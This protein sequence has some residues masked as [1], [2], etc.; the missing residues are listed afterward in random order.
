MPSRT[1]A[2]STRLGGLKKD[3]EKPRVWT[4]ASSA[5]ATTPSAVVASR[6]SSTAEL[7]GTVSAIFR[8]PAGLPSLRDSTPRRVEHKKRG[9]HE[10]SC[11]EAPPE[12]ESGDTRSGRDGARKN[13]GE[14]PS[15][16]PNSVTPAHLNETV[17]SPSARL[18][19][20][21]QNP[22][23]YRSDG[24]RLTLSGVRDARQVAGLSAF[25]SQVTTAPRRFSSGHRSALHAAPCQPSNSFQATRGSRTASRDVS[26]G[27]NRY[28]E[29]EDA[30]GSTLHA[31]ASAA[32]PPSSRVAE[33]KSSSCD[34]VAF[35]DAE[36]PSGSDDKRSQS[37]ADTGGVLNK[38]RSASAL[39]SEGVS[40]WEKKGEEGQKEERQ[41]SAALASVYLDD[42]PAE[43]VVA[44]LEELRSFPR[45]QALHI[46]LWGLDWTPEMIRLLGQVFAASAAT[47]ESVTLRCRVSAP[48]LTEM[49]ERLPTNVRYLDVSENMLGGDTTVVP[50]L[51]TLLRRNAIESLKVS[52]VGWSRESKELFAKAV[53]N[54]G[55]F[56]CLQWLEGVDLSEW[57]AIPPQV[58]MQAA[59]PGPPCSS[60]AATTAPLAHLYG[61]RSGVS[62]APGA[63]RAAAVAL[64]K[65]LPATTVNYTLL[66][67][68]RIRTFLPML[69]GKKVRVWWKPTSETQRTDFS[70]R[71]WPAR[72]V[73]G[74]TD[75]LVCKL[76]YDNNEQDFIS[77]RYLQPY[78]PFKY[79]G[80]WGCL[81]D[82]FPSSS[83]VSSASSSSSSSQPCKSFDMPAEPC[84][85]SVAETIRCEA[86]VGR[87]ASRGRRS[88]AAAS[89]DTF[90]L[91][92]S[93]SERLSIVSEASPVVSPRRGRR[94]RR[95]G[96]AARGAGLEVEETGE[97][98]ETRE[99]EEGDTVDAGS[100][101][102]S[103]RESAGISARGRRRR[104]PR[105][106]A[107]LFVSAP[108]QDE[109]TG[110]QTQRRKRRRSAGSEGTEARQSA[111]ENPG[112]ECFLPPSEKGLLQRASSSGR[113]ACR[114]RPPAPTRRS[115]ESKAPFGCGRR[116]SP[117][118]QLLAQGRQKSH[119]S[120]ESSRAQ[121]RE[122]P[123]KG[124]GPVG[125]GDRAASP[126]RL[127][128]TLRGREGTG[129]SKERDDTETGVMREAQKGVKTAR[130]GLGEF[131]REEGL[132]GLGEDRAECVYLESTDTGRGRRRRS[133]EKSSQDGEKEGGRDARHRAGSRESDDRCGRREAAEA[134]GIG[135]ALERSIGVAA[136]A[137]TRMTREG[138]A[139]HV[140][141]TR[142]GGAGEEA[143]VRAETGASR[144]DKD[145]GE[146]REQ[147]GDRPLEQRRQRGDCLSPGTDEMRDQ[148][149]RD[150]A[151]RAQGTGEQRRKSDG[152]PLDVAW[153]VCCGPAP[154]SRQEV[155]A[156][157]S[158][159]PDLFE[160]SLYT[161]LLSPERDG[162][163]EEASERKRAA[164]REVGEERKARGAPGE[165]F[166][167]A[168][169]DSPAGDAN[170]K[171]CSRPGSRALGT[172]R[173][174]QEMRKAKED[175]EK[176]EREKEGEA[177]E[178]GGEKGE[179][180]VVFETLEDATVNCEEGR[181][182]VG[183][184][185]L[186]VI[187]NVLLPGELCEF[188]DEEEHRGSDPSDFVGMVVAV[189]SEEP[190]YVVRCV[191]HDDDTLLQIQ[192]SDIRR[193]VVVPLDAW[194][195]WRFA[196]ERFRLRSEESSSTD[197]AQRGA[198]RAVRNRRE[199]PPPPASAAPLG[200][201]K[202]VGA[203]S[204]EL[205][206]GQACVPERRAEIRSPLNLGSGQ[207]ETNLPAATAFPSFR[208]V[209]PFAAFYMLPIATS[210]RLQQMAAAG[211]PSQP[212]RSPVDLKLL[213][214][215]DFAEDFAVRQV[216][217]ARE[218]QEA[219]R[220]EREAGGISAEETESGTKGTAPLN[221]ALQSGGAPHTNVAA[222]V[223]P[224]WGQA[225]AEKLGR[226]LTAVKEEESAKAAKTRKAESE[227]KAAAEAETAA[228]ASAE[229]AVVARQ[230][231]PHKGFG[232]RP[233]PLVGPRNK[234]MRPLFT[235]LALSASLGSEFVK[236]Q[237]HPRIQQS[238][239]RAWLAL[240]PKADLLQKVID[241]SRELATLKVQVQ[242]EAAIL[243]ECQRLR[244]SLEKQKEREGELESLLKCIICVSRTRSV[245]LAPCLHFYFCHS[246]SQGL[247][248][249][250]ICR[251]K[252]V[253][254]IQVKREQ[255]ADEESDAE[256]M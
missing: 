153:D 89:R 115:V 49:L 208:E 6:R 80:G 63:S 141:S 117:R 244:V 106:K 193:A 138:L 135:D 136:R 27:T 57:L 158:L 86:R 198:S 187:G 240:L 60:V 160:Q 9:F 26:G 246:C 38:S 17:P 197:A 195:A 42:A 215:Q 222:A 239:R 73:H 59:V 207:R 251:G 66:R 77:L 170:S 137:K 71:Y 70:G 20:G 102:T 150:E 200:R 95:Q 235:F 79:G 19:Q 232:P 3:M 130:S 154:V 109:E 224:E 181:V 15:S 180:E 74:C 32:L 5:A 119:G 120:H 199:E 238:D 223:H 139:A 52:Q 93:V 159:Y 162:E 23:M 83:S 214:A 129:A 75:T 163:A 226:A 175:T 157:A 116:V 82:S 210:T 88:V 33:A 165:S 64:A 192:S 131:Q 211:R 18:S 171:E 16:A 108:R 144:G 189:N 176:A 133:R 112:T 167:P 100:F 113:Q 169:S 11:T 255:G 76:V 21:F 151:L 185:P 122:E 243:E 221:Q 48:V 191:Y 152:D 101:V 237:L 216:T 164:G 67:Y 104:P 247:T 65:S 118:L 146:R 24:H 132:E 161:F 91:S 61:H 166:A 249:C 12:G 218:R 142:R 229:F 149:T 252:I 205:L 184:M 220:T 1:C 81:T 36:R 190:L 204:P 84:T 177:Q 125:C 2:S 39:S 143:L 110:D 105:G 28:R 236:Q 212:Q 97:D 256:S 55:V 202:R 94:Q 114:L 127:R 111:E 99:D 51:D 46:H 62:G 196:L 54:L 47:L 37:H 145:E 182:R 87:G 233:C 29:F 31:S 123:V 178:K 34:A 126:L 228:Y 186:A 225:Q 217:F 85:V 242:R 72:V 234:A 248:Q 148:Q 227:E 209:P 245:A 124:R 68:L 231:A 56:N 43:V 14:T 203:T 30:N 121:E 107:S 53:E 140:C 103:E 22:Q 10:S 241:L 44:A 188:R 230:R 8:R 92:S 45:L 168:A 128:R 40:L 155:A 219:M 156:A 96:G 7:E 250:P 35:A 206:Q 41:V 58:F 179:T 201:T 90:A 147:A 50:V 253:S 194:I 172:R 254:R 173:K 183:R 4:K 98:E 213:P 13:R 25:L 69:V 78:H 134:N 174:T